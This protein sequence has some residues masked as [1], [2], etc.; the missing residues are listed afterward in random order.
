VTEGER[1]LQYRTRARV[2][3]IISL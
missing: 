1:E 2:C 3:M